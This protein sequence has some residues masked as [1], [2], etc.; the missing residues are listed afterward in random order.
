[1]V[2]LV[3]LEQC[4]NADAPILITPL[5]ILTLVRLQQAS[6]ALVAITLTPFGILTEVISVEVTWCK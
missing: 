2:T 3:R 5:G 1:M 4:A 6:N